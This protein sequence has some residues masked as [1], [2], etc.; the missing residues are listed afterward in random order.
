[1]GISQLHQQERLAAPAR[2]NSG[3]SFTLLPLRVAA[4]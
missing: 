4:Y 3:G 2:S 1:M